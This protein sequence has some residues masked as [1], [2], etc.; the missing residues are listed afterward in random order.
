MEVIQDHL[1]DVG[2]DVGLNVL[3][4]LIAAALGILLYSAVSNRRVEKGA[5]PAPAENQAFDAR[6]PEVSSTKMEFIPLAG[7]PGMLPGGSKT[8]G[9]CGRI[10]QS[11]RRNRSEVIRLA[12]EMLKAGAA[13]ATIK[14]RVPI[15][16]GELAILQS[17]NSQ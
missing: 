14:R 8:I 16:D 10:S 2:L 13:G 7:T 6:T 12:R 17:G 3:G 9:D 11:G 1:I 15:S 4:Y 5:G